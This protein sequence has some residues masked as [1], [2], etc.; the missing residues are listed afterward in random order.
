MTLDGV[1]SFSRINTN[2]IHVNAFMTVKVLGRVPFQVMTEKMTTT[3]GYS[4]LFDVSR[5]LESK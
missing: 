1:T 3:E 5:V 2:E 4:C